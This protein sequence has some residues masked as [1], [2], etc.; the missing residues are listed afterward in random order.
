MEKTLVLIKPDAVERNIVGEI[1]TFYEKQNLKITALKMLKATEDMAHL[2]Y[3]IHEDKPFF[4]DL[5]AYITRS[6]LCALI[7]EGDNAIEKVRK[8]NGNTDPS[9]AEQNTIRGTF[10]VSKTENS[11]HA[12][13]STETAQKEISIWF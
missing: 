4:K 8:I 13:D 1:L 9:K 5:I 12:S 6:P 10:A 2:H 7:L 3:K 11:V